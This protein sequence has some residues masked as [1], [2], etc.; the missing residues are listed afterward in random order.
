ME[1]ESAAQLQNLDLRNAPRLYASSQPI[2]LAIRADKDCS[3]VRQWGATEENKKELEKTLQHVWSHCE[4]G[5]IGRS[6]SICMPATSMVRTGL[7]FRF[8]LS[9]LTLLRR[10]GC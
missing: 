4:V 10:R 9:G 8:S 7:R 3:V 6:P 2:P 5:E 1:S